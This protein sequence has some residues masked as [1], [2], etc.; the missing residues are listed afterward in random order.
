M[1]LLKK[2]AKELSVF[3]LVLV[4]F[5]GLFAYRTITFKGYKE[6]SQTQL[7]EKVTAKEDFIVV[8]GDSSTSD[9]YSFTSIMEEF[10]TKNRDT[11]LFYVDSYE[12]ED[13]N[14]WLDETLN[15]AV[16]YPST[17]IV[18]DGAVKASKDGALQ[19]YYLKDFITNN[20]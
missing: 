1:E 16:T 12:I 3:G 11:D 2:F 8:V 14:T 6:I 15:I 19:Y 10:T 9:M 18:E 7:E 20:K 13:F 4:I 5:L 17:I